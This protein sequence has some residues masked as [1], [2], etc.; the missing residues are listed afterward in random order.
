MD[1]PFYEQLTYVGNARLEQWYELENLGLKTLP[2]EFCFPRS[3]CHA[4]SSHIL[5]HCCMMM[6]KRQT[7]FSKR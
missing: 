1:C 5:Y 3:D 2:E 4:W 7:G 6:R